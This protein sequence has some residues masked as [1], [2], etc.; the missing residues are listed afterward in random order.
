MSCVI[1]GILK[2]RVEYMFIKKF[3]YMVVL[4]VK[5]ELLFLGFK[6]LYI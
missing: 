2:N 4:R 6:D 1:F 3:M 5:E